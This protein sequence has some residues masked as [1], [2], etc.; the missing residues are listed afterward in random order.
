MRTSWQ[1]LVYFFSLGLMWSGS[2]GFTWMLIDYF[3]NKYRGISPDEEYM[4]ETILSRY[5][6]SVFFFGGQIR[7]GFRSS[8]PRNIFINEGDYVS[9]WIDR[10][11][12]NGI[13]IANLEYCEGG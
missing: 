1:D 6:A 11:N 9:I 3:I 10:K 12:N 13:N 7:I 4:I 5:N 2:G 8:F